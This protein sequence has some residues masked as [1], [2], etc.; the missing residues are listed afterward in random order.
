MGICIRLLLLWS[1]A[2][3]LVFS[4]CFLLL[5]DLILAGFTDKREVIQT[6]LNYWGWVV[7]GA[8]ISNFAYIW[9]G[10]YIGLTA[11]KAIRNAML[12]CATVFF[13][14]YFFLIEPLG[15]LGL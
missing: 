11:N 12:V 6:S 1:C 3:A 14:A 7:F 9:D 2:V 8:F 13:S 10:I 4:M 15:N 5:G